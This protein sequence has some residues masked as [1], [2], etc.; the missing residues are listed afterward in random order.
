MP[1]VITV[2]APV[3]PRVCGGTSNTMSPGLLL[4]GLSPRVRGNPATATEAMMSGGSIPA[5]AGEPS[6]RSLD[7]RQP[8]VY[9]RVCG[10]TGMADGAGRPGHGLSPRV[11]GN[12]R[13]ARA[14][15]R[16]D[17]SIPACAG[18]PAGEPGC[19]LMTRV[20]PR[21]CGGTRAAGHHPAARPG[22][23]PRV[24]GNPVGVDRQD[25]VQGSIPACAGEPYRR[26][27]S[28]QALGVYPRVCGGT[29]T[30]SGHANAA[31]GLSPRVRGNRRDC[32]R[33][34]KW[35]GSIPACAGEPRALTDAH[36]GG[37]VYPRVCGGTV[38]TGTGKPTRPGLSPRVRGNPGKMA[39]AAGA[40]RSIP[41]CAGEPRQ[42]VLRSHT[43]WVYPRVCGGT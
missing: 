16:P 31:S 24:R 26:S 1:C 25:G 6:I 12:R 36:I 15:G 8:A 22:L 9:P 28:S 41:A 23:S 35:A 29:A 10:G 11:R 21:V 13:P 4:A 34:A 19:N 39:T 3:Y 38:S 43:E 5:C 37:K 33:W 30:A 32:R 40:T 20:Y 27:V 42:R 18:E 7:N 17:G 2:L 14:L